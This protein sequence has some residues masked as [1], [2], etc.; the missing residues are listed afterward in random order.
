M[1]TRWQSP[2]R[3]AII[4]FLIGT[5]VGLATGVFAVGD[6]W[7]EEIIPALGTGIGIAVAFYFVAGE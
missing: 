6:P 1:T 7:Q 3:K 4:G 5:T 2:Y